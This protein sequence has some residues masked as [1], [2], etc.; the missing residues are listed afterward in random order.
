MRIIFFVVCLGLSATAAYYGEPYIHNNPDAVLVFATVF[1]VFAGFL[2]G[3]ITIIGDPTLIPEGTWRAAEVR[4]ESIEARL[5]NHIWLFMLYLIAIGLLFA[6][7]IVH[8]APSDIVSE[9]I[10][11][12]VGRL[13]LF[14]GVLSFLLTFGLP[15]SL[16][17]LQMA[18][19]DAEIKRRRQDVGIQDDKSG[20]N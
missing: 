1:T 14:V 8:K 17:K 4:R 20:S 6:L 5:V 7:V 19:I 3:V 13:C 11:V 15:G 2:V 18:R 12:W 10:K 16:L 9:C